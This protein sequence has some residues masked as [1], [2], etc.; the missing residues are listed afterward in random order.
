VP[1]DQIRNEQAFDGLIRLLQTGHALG[2]TGAGL[3]IWAGY[4]TWQQVIDRSAEAVR[5]RRGP[6]VN[7]DVVLKNNRNLLH[8]AQ[9]LGD[10]LGRPVFEQFMRAE[11][12]RGLAP[13]LRRSDLSVA[14]RFR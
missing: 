13:L 5:Q 7:V 1:I 8:C 12:S 3:S 4:G 2:V 11:F 10:Y 6:E 9:R 14:P